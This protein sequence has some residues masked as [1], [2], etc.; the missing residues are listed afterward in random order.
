MEFFLGTSMGSGSP[1]PGG[2]S[3]GKGFVCFFKL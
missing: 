2:M 1:R 3:L